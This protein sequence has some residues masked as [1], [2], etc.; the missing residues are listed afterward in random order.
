MAAVWSSGTFV[1]GE[2]EDVYALGC[3]LCEILMGKNKL[4]GS[5][6]KQISQKYGHAVADLIYGMTCSSVLYNME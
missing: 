2:D 4:P 5:C 6:I 1:F 3:V